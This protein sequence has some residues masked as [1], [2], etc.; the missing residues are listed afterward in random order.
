M[1]MKSR[2]FLTTSVFIL[3]VLC[4]RTMVLAQNIP[5]TVT[6]DPAK[7]VR[8]ISPLIYGINAYVF[9]DEWKTEAEWKVG[10]DNTAPG[11]NVGQRRMGGNTM[12]SYN[13]ENGFCNSGV[14]SHN[15]NND[16]QSYIS[17]A[18]APPYAPGI[19]LTTFHGHTLTL[20][21]S[22]LLQLP[23]AGYVAADGNG[24]VTTP[25]PSD[26][27]KAVAFAKSGAP[28]SFSLTPDLNDNTVYVDEEV[29]F[30]VNHFG[31][32]SSAHG[33]T[34]YELDNEPGLWHTPPDQ[35]GAAGTHPLLHAA[36]TT[37]QDLLTRNIA[38]ATTV[39]TVD[40]TASVYGPAMWGYPE[41]YSYWSVY[42]GANTLQPSDW[43][44]FNV[45]PYLT[46]NTND[47]YRYNH[48]TWLNAY[49][50]NMK[51]ASDA[52][53]K[54]LLDVFSLH[55]YAIDAATPETRVQAPRS[56]WDP[57]Y[58][59]NSYITTQGNGFTD[60]RALQLIPIVQRSLTDFYPDTKFA[61]T[62]WDFGGRHDITGTIAQADALGIFGRYNVY[63]ADYFNPVEDFIAAAFRIYRNYDGTNGTFGE[64]SISAVTSDITNSS[65][66]A[67]TSSDGLTHV[68][69]INKSL[70]KDEDVT[71]NLHGLFVDVY[72]IQGTSTD[73][74]HTPRQAFT[75]SYTFPKASVTHLVI[76]QT[77]SIASVQLLPSL[78]LSTNPASNRTDIIGDA[79][80]VS[81]ISIRIYDEL[82]RLAQPAT[83]T[84][85]QG[86]FLV[87]LNVESLPVGA[88]QVVVESGSKLQVMKLAV[89]R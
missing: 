42:D 63:A 78:R 70:T 10:L 48:M 56:L 11:V 66:Y 55:Y 8:P 68:I 46:N 58:V 17:G 1:S 86:R 74:V 32:A 37:C 47:T 29:N 64:T 26:R 6:I 27:W 88:Y 59:E 3:T 15:E 60:G 44:T 77:N 76:R 13:W 87:P 5:I 89:V 25:A 36:I 57:S 4:T 41:Y 50:A 34:A 72:Q 23:C 62:E 69:F 16:F 75:N 19:A 40:P 81:N 53:G 7:D 31:N 85:T 39:K 54:R 82:G 14:D 12:T 73:I 30:V 79:A 28:N 22:S 51:K 52:A 2:L 71:F 33:L 35:S 65:C 80:V 20:N 61:I 38:L 24:A 84:K 45:E 43:P 67:S 83:V 18:G 21:S 9:D 49:L